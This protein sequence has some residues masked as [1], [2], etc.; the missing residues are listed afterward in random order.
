VLST[1]KVYV[2][3]VSFCFSGS[4]IIQP[5]IENA[6]QHGLN[7]KLTQKTAP[8]KLY[9]SAQEKNGY[10][11][12]DITDNGIGMPEEKIKNLFSTE[13]QTPGSS[14]GIK[15]ISERIKLLCGEEY[16]LNITSKE[17]YYTTA[18]LFLPIINNN[19]DTD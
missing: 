8:V 19:S 15:N 18:S 14:I 12:I 1:K 5:L 13:S 7:E 2:P 16:G 9:I 3:F 4:M 17:G 10:L 11:I 6:I